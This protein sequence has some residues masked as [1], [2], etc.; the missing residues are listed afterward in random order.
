[1]KV[2]QGIPIVKLLPHRV[3]VPYDFFVEEIVD[4]EAPLGY[5]YEVRPA[6]ICWLENLP[7]EDSDWEFDD[8]DVSVMRFA[9]ATR[10][11][12]RWFKLAWT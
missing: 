8:V 10:Q 11:Q 5:A 2:H 7:F 12:A 1:M 4:R 6:L 3:E 9:F